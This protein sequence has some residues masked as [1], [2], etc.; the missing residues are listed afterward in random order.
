M[1]R[2]SDGPVNRL[3][4]NAQA[5]SRRRRA[6]AQLAA[7]SLALVLC[8]GEHH[9]ASAAGVVGSG[10]PESCTEAALD[11]ALAG[12]GVVTFNCGAEP[13]T[14]TITG[15][16]TISQDTTVDGD[17]GITLSGNGHVGV[18]AVGAGVSAGIRALTIANGATCGG[19][20]V[21]G[22]G[23]CNLGTLQMSSC[24]LVNNRAI[25]GVACP[26]MGGGIFNSGTL[27]L[28]NCTLSS[29]EAVQGGGIANFN[30][31]ATITNSTLAANSAQVGGGI[32]NS[33]T[34]AI[35]IS[36]TIVANSFA[37]DCHGSVID[38]GHNLI[39][40]AAS[41]CGLTNGVK[42]NFVGIDPLLDP[43][44]LKDNGGPTQTIALLAGSPA[45]NAGDPRVCANAPVNGVDQRGY[46]RPGAG[47]ANCSI[48]AFEY[49]SPGPPPSC[50]GDCDGDEEVTVGEIMLMV[51][52]ALD[53]TPLPVCNNGDGNVDGAIT[54]EEIITAVIHALYGCATPDVSGTRRRDQAVIR[55]STCAAAV[56]ANVQNSIDA[57]AWDCTYEI[58][59]SGPYLTVSE[60]CPEGTD[61][62]FGTVDSSGRI[63]TFRAEQETQDS[64]VL[65]RTSRFQADGRASGSTGA[66]RLQ[67]A[68]SP[69]CAFSDCVMVVESRFSRL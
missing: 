59:Q 1:K 64:C 22:G 43:A 55:S 52:V 25:A 15:T 23:V 16:K 18:L 58:M 39:E 30:G 32:A 61:T 50:T 57:G 19:A 66:G 24:T 6:A 3:V 29:N 40:G 33:E 8:C 65:T 60:T 13:V 35:T 41:S 12:G 47:A 56:T 67:F 53:P 20:C 28:S 62:F 46:V 27:H 14:I 2:M 45:I 4:G 37:G 44:G 69:G 21:S 9:A 34:G 5:Q 10:T 7:C 42:G 68:F 49:D 11:A 31:M 48:G 63:T 51:N 36:N 17:G 54:V 38:G 26:G